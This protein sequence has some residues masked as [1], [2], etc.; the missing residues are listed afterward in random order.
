M[1]IKEK[2]QYL[3]MLIWSLNATISEKGYG[4]AIIKHFLSFSTE[5]KILQLKVR[6]LKYIVLSFFITLPP[7]NLF[8]KLHYIQYIVD[9][10]VF[11][12]REVGVND[13][14]FSCL[15]ILVLKA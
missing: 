1:H 9:V 8:V 7:R 15:K 4:S 11:F 10:G 6:I 14:K 12:L 2:N 3:E 13:L 5:N